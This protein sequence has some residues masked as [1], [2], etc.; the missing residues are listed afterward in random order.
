M[1]TEKLTTN[2]LQAIQLLLIGT[3]LNKI[4]KA[5]KIDP[6]TLWDWRQMPEFKAELERKKHEFYE[7]TTG[8][9]RG[10][11]GTATEQLSK[12]LAD[13]NTPVATKLRAVEFIVSLIK[14]QQQ[15]LDILAATK[16]LIENNAIEPQVLDKIN[17]AFT[18]FEKELKS[19]FR[20]QTID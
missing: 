14:P 4:S 3:P 5:C 13:Q 19:A 6:S 17:T 10:M 18:T 11:I 9:I 16:V 2:Q 1:A 12:L 8:V 20:S 15:Q 7:E